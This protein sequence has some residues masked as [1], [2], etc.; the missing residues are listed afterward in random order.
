MEDR[1]LKKRILL[2]APMLPAIGGISVSVSRLKEHLEQDGFEVVTYNMQTVRSGIMRYLSLF[3]ITLRLPF[4][5]LFEERFDLIHF[6]ISSYWRRIYLWMLQFLFKRTKTVVTF[7]RDIEKELK[8]PFARMILR[9]GDRLI[10]VRKGNRMLMPP[11]LKKRTVEIPAFIMPANIGVLDDLPKTLVDFIMD[12][13][14]NGHRLL[15][16]NGAIVLGNPYNDLY[17]LIFPIYHFVFYKIAIHNHNLVPY[18]FQS[19][20]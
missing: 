18:V 19:K 11:V 2:V 8:Y 7:H 15:V 13:V 4:F 17:I 5:I 9:M 3:L 14:N 12:A 20:A 10:C 6:H 16:F 1:Q